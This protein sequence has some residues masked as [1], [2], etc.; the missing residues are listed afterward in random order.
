MMA[1]QLVSRRFLEVFGP[2]V[3]THSRFSSIS[4]NCLLLRFL[5]L[6]TF[7]SSPALCKLHNRD[8]GKELP[9]NS[10]EAILKQEPDDDDDGDEGSFG[11]LSQKFSNRRFFRK[12]TP[13]FYNLQLQMEGKEEDEPQPK[14]RHGPKNTP[15]WYFLQCKA[16]IKNNKLKEALDLFE[17][18]MLKEERVFPEES[19]YTVLIGGCGRV[20]YLKKAF[21]L[22][23]DMKKRDLQPSDATY[24]ALFNACAES[25]WKD[26]GLQAALKLRQ[27]LL[28]KNVEMSLITYHALLKACALCSDLQMCFEILKEIVQKGHQITTDTFNFLL[29]GCIKDKENGFRY[30]LQVWQQMRKLSL[31]PDS[32]SYNL[33]LS[34]ARECGLGDPGVASDLLLRPSG[35][36]SAIPRLGDGGRKKRKG[37]RGKAAEPGLCTQLDIEIL[38][39]SIFPGENRKAEEQNTAAEARRASNP[40]DATKSKEL[41]LYEKSCTTEADAEDALH[42]PNLLDLQTTNK[43]VVSLGTVSTASDRLALMGNMEGFLQKMKSDGAEPNIKTYTLLS[44][45]VQPGSPSEASL[46]AAMEE[47][48]VKAD[49]TFFN[50]LIR[51]KSKTAD[52]EGA[53]S[54]M[55]MLRK[56]GLSPNLQTFCNLAIACRKQK[57]GLQLLSDMKQSAQNPNVHIYSTLINAAVKRLDY[58]YLIEILKDMRNTQVPPNE[59]VIRQLEFA[60]QYPPHFDRY[61]TKDPYLERIDGFRAYYFRWLKWMEAEETPHPWAKYRTP[62]QPEMKDD[63]DDGQKHRSEMGQ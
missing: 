43:N 25:P 9:A 36:G 56:K 13:E 63:S 17:T 16:L 23:D 51:K 45:V 21:K 5:G 24:T 12:A 58:A 31:K 28:S 44:E 49:I 34:A 18:Q 52:L 42:L 26:T 6:R 2:W 61:K 11:T 30:A 55:P 57:D 14:P 48:N 46:L 50:T 20:G 32:Y 60:A 10:S 47:D 27:Q 59:V 53:K 22:Y 29:M 62:K 38:E 19:N 8:L 33:M 7:S 1:V 15:Y 54:L 40:T 37:Q 35:E 41:M 3:S 4:K 39:K